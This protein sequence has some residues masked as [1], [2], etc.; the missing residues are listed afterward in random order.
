MLCAGIAPAL[1]LLG[2]ESGSP[3]LGLGGGALGFIGVAAWTGRP[4]LPTALLAL[5]A[6]PVPVFVLEHLSPGLETAWMTATVGVLSKFGVALQQTGP[7]AFGVD[8][9]R[10][11]F[12]AID[13]GLLLA[14]GMAL[15]GFWSALRRGDAVLQCAA[16]ALA[17]A[18]AGFGLQALVLI[19][20][21]GTTAGGNAEAAFTILVRGPTCVMAIGIAGVLAFEAR[22]RRQSALPAPTPSSPL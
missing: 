12:F 10:V 11:E 8:G 1:I 13:D 17:F 19:A 9:V 4:G 16:R 5:W 15:V 3:T 14:H 21:A 6:L 7:V 18:L 20:A 2:L 22:R